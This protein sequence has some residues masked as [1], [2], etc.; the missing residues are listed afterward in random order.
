MLVKSHKEHSV[1]GLTQSLETKTSPFS[2]LE[3]QFDF[4]CRSTRRW[5]CNCALHVQIQIN[6]RGASRDTDRQRNNQIRQLK[7]KSSSSRRSHSMQQDPPP[8]LCHKIYETWLAR[9]ACTNLQD[10]NI[11]ELG[12]IVSSSPKMSS[13]CYVIIENIVGILIFIFRLLH[14]SC[15]PAILTLPL[16]CKDA[17]SR[18]LKPSDKRMIPLVFLQTHTAISLIILIIDYLVPKVTQKSL[19]V[20]CQVQH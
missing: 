15:L 20:L 11:N 12:I 9:Q 3:I 18:E 7:W 1:K 10:R 14:I 6:S 8:H 4:K 16:S 2:R 5:H 17:L 13:V 19:R